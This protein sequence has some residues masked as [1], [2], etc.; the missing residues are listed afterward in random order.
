L[1]E[2]SIMPVSFENRES[3]CVVHLDGEVG[4]PSAAELKSA[5]G[6]AL[7]SGK[8]ISIDLQKATVLDITALQLMWAV[9]RGVRDAGLRCVV[10]GEVP[11]SLV[12]GAVDA[13]FK[14]FPVGLL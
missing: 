12:S 9:E 1:E 7:D 2:A 8:E 11:K 3:T 13:G 14:K 10:I 5:L 6:L 4:I